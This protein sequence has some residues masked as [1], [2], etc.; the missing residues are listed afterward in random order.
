[1]ARIFMPGLKGIWERR[2]R[3]DWTGVKGLGQGPGARRP[4]GDVLKCYPLYGPI[5]THPK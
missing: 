3:L 2:P 4:V 5:F 1:M